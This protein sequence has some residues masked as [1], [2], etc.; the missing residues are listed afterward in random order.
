MKKIFLFYCVP[1]F[2]LFSNCTNKSDKDMIK[3]ISL[4]IRYDNPGDSLNSWSRRSSVIT[5][6]IKSEKPD[7][8]GFQEVLFNQY[9]SLDS[10]LTNYGSAGVGRE[11]GS[12][13]G[14]MNPIFFLKERFDL[15]R[16]KTFWLSETPERPG[17]ISWESSLP[18]IVTWVELA[19]KNTH[20]HIFIFNT[21]FAHDS[22]SARTMSS[23]LLLARIDSIAS[24]F[25]FILTGDFN[26]VLS[27]RGYEILT[28]PFESVPL[29]NDTYAISEKRHIGPAYT[30]NGFSEKS[31]GERIDYIFVRNGMKVLE[32]RTLIR[33]EHGI[34]I[35]DHWPV[36]AIVSPAMPEQ[37]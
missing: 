27:S 29:L 7:I 30:F 15:V 6:F 22:D 21:H 10:I 5:N 16:N 20:Q 32:N 26:M 35:S 25:P 3:V 1:V 13:G 28:G 9:E 11:D 2:L 14:E 23:H 17:S 4:N 19:E 8:F 18:R 33:K 34:Y 24:G 36:M 12:H 37:K 31:P